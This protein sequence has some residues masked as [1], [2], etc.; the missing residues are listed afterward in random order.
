MGDAGIDWETLAQAETHKDR[1]A[2][3]ETMSTNPHQGVGRRLN[4]AGR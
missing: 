1:M 3:I 4:S 2:I